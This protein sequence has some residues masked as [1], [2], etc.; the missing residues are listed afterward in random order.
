MIENKNEKEKNQ[1]KV[2]EK[3]EKKIHKKRKAKKPDLSTYT[4][5]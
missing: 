2:R 5:Q 3:S 1:R 4:L